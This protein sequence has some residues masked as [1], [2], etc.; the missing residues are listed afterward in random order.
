MYS[1]ETFDSVDAGASET[2]P[3]EAGQIKKGGYICIKGRPCKVVSIS[4][5]KTGK[6]GHAKCNFVAIDIFTGKKLEDI[7]PSSHSTTVPN[8]FKTEYSL[9][10]ISDENYLSLMDSNGEIREDLKMPTHPNEL[11]EQIRKGFD[12]DDSLILY[13]YKA[14]NEEHVMSCRKDNS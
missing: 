7:V 12:N 14:M 6:H 1:D 2:I 4:T 11:V 5:S 10:D 8:V 9:L 13:I 3:M